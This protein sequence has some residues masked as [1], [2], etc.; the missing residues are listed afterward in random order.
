MRLIL[1]LVFGIGGFA[2]LMALGIWQLQ[3]LEWK[4][5]VIAEIEAR[6]DDAPTPLPASPD[7]ARD[8]F[9]PVR[10]DAEI[11]GAPLRVLGAWRGGGSGF[12]IVVP[13]ETA[14][15]RRLLVDLGIVPLEAENPLAAAPEG[16][17]A[18]TGNLSW[19]DDVTPGT[20]QP[21]G[22]LWYARDVPSM[23]AALDTEPL[24]VVARDVAPAIAP[25]PVPVG[26][27][28][29]ANSHLGYAIQWFALALVWAGMTAYLGWRIRRR[30]I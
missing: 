6:I 30:T 9:R 20:P 13:A 29:I 17:L 19:P 23:A 7:P 1:P 18:I 3:R 27:E 14:E 21:E 26:T 25:R 22:D 11:A 5:A 10:L 8:N 4:E 2:V 15:G 12:R 24:L 16:P 28:G